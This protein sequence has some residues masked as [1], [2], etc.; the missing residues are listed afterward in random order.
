MSQLTVKELIVKLQNENQD[1]LVW[2]ESRGD[3][4]CEGKAI[5]IKPINSLDINSYHYET[6][7]SKSLI[8]IEVE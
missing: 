5:N 1:S 2:V 3:C 6:D 7:E 4:E 8:L